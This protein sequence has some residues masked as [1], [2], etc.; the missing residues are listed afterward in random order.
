[1]DGCSLRYYK[2]N[3]LG[4]VDDIV[5]DAPSAKGLQIL[6]NKFSIMISEL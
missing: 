4:Y 5:L 1:M 3:I 6:L 2:T